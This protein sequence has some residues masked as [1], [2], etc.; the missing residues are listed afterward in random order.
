MYAYL[1]QNLSILATGGQLVASSVEFFSVCL[2][3]VI[4]LNTTCHDWTLPKHFHAKTCPLQWLN[5][6]LY[7]LT[8]RLVDFGNFDQSFL[9][10]SIRLVSPW[11]PEKKHFGLRGAW[12]MDLLGGVVTFA[13]RLCPWNLGSGFFVSYSAGTVCIQLCSS[14][15]R[16][17][18]SLGLGQ[19]S[20]M[21]SSTLA[22]SWLTSA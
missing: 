7:D 8:P 16:K 22:T 11:S 12:K 19:R 17:T 4:Y 1:S 5:A 2:E 21:P 9:F 20:W 3:V 13:A 14:S 18:P 6:T 15:F 10:L